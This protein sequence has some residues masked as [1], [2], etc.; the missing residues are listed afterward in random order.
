MPGI[1]GGHVADC[2]G[3]F[4]TSRWK[5]LAH[6]A[7]ALV[8]ALTI[9]PA[10]GVSA[11][12]KSNSKKQASTSPPAKKAKDS[13]NSNSSAS[14]SSGGSLAS[15]GKNKLKSLPSSAV[16][17]EDIIAYI[18][19]QIRAGWD[20]AELKPSTHATDNEWCR[21]VY[22]DVVGRIPT[23]DE[24]QHFLASPPGR[25]KVALLNKL[26]DSDAYIDEYARNWTTVWSNV[27][28]GRPPA[29]VNRRDPTS[30][31]GMQQYLRRSFLE[32]K[33]WDRMVYEM[34]SATGS[35]APGSKDYNGATNFLVNKLQEN[36]IEATAKT[37]KYFLGIQVQCT[38]CHNHPFNDW[39]QEQFWNLNAFFRQTHSEVHKEGKDISYT[40]LKNSDFRG[41][42][43]TPSD[44]EIYFELRNGTLQVAYPTFIDGTKLPTSG[45][46]KDVDR[47]TEL[48]R[49][50]VKSDYL[51]R[52][53]VNRLWGHF[54]GYGFTKPVDDFGP[55]NPPSHPELLDQLGVE[56][57]RHG[58]DL[59]RLIRWIA[60][61]EA[62]GLSSRMTE[63][64]RKDDPALGERPK[65]SHFYLR[66]MQAEQLYESLLVV[67]NAHK[68]SGSYEEK[69]GKKADVLRQFTI[70]FGNADGEDA[71]T[72]NGTIPQTLMMMNGSIIDSTISVDKGSMLRR[73]ANGSSQNDAIDFLYMTTL[74]RKPANADTAM[75]HSLVGSRTSPLSGYQDLLW[76]LLNSNEF[77]FIH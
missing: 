19:E 16:R 72:F 66:Q 3:R 52:A 42:G 14:K 44:A 20:D 12:P 34:V 77:I 13:N 59:K 15:G 21:R 33:P 35:T 65:F 56:F 45:Y 39:K 24:L 9:A 11:A 26:L 29:R 1:A 31:A 58:Y 49:F 73:L 25:K 30:R 5:K 68:A 74:A 47:R 23:A 4:R 60:L 63:N 76:A 67:A 43:S 41:E 10:A 48:A 50:V 51:G 28:I 18:D 46:L 70:T 8:A 38:Q 36:A 7:L 40:L 64:N 53:I 32:N 57:S 69:E 71:T 27:L 75:A 55:H 2:G 37:A 54:L 6:V 61:S 17:D 62:Y 22:L